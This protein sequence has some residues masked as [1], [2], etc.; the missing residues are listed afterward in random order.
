L[1]AEA[2]RIL[3]ERGAAEVGL[4]EVARAVGVSHNAPYRHYANREALIAD[5]AAGGFERLAA[6][7]LAIPSSDPAERLVDIGFGYVQF[8]FAE[9]AI[10]R[11]MFAPELSKPEYPALKAAA[12]EVFAL[13]R[14]EL[15]DQ[16]VPPPATVEAVTAWAT[17]HGLAILFLDDRIEE[18]AGQTNR[19]ETVRRAIQIFLA[20]LR[21]NSA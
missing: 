13:V 5:I 20:G 6:R 16:G 14:S 18:H 21:S 8:A 4:R 7:F 19:E 12:D 11:L 3:I 15:L 1:R 2:E 17:V 10:F 9:Q